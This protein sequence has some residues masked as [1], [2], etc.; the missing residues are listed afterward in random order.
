MTT[1]MGNGGGVGWTVT[2]QMEVTAPDSTGR[3]VPGVKVSFTTVTGLSGT[4]F[5]PDAQYNTER[6]RAAI[7]ERVAQMLAVHGLGG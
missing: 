2:G 5:V 4:V 6:V 1:G 3:Y 7:N